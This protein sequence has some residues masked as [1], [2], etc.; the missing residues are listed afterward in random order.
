MVDDKRSVTRVGVI[1]CGYW[2]PNLVR[3]LTEN[4][5]VRVVKVSDLQPGRLAFISQRHPNIQTTLQA[6]E[7]LSDPDIEA[8][9]IA[10]PPNTHFALASQALEAGKHVLV[11]KPLA[12]TA[13]DAEQLVAIANRKRL[14]LSVGHLFLYAPAVRHLRDLLD[15]GELG[16][17]HY[18]SSVRANLGPPNTQVD[19]L[20]DL[21]PHDLS[22][23][24]HLMGEFPEEV[25]AQGGFFTNQQLAEAVSMVLRFPSGRMG[26]V[27]VSW[28]TPNKTRIM[29]LVCSKKVAVYDDTELVQKVRIFNCGIDSRLQA[30]ETDSIALAYRP[31]GIWIPP[32]DG[33]EPLRAEC[34]DF[35]RA[36]E[37]GKPPLSDGANAIGVVRI[38]Q[39]ASESLR[40]MAAGQNPVVSCRSV[41]MS[42]ES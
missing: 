39:S 22:I 8:V 33:R 12:T 17:V 3:C 28:L 24:L 26:Y 16:N 40:R 5:C 6:G 13:E 36:I 38:L 1:G 2:G 4:E 10:T 34:D 27:F 37:S 35:I 29:Q 25:V 11:E 19:V 31:G 14:I 41:S 9:A 32:L 42:V 30:K 7:I 15:A 23:L 21:A 18:I 20:W